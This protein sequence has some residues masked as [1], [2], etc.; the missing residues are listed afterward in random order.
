MILD[1][2]KL[3]RRICM[4]NPNYYA[5]DSQLT[6]PFLCYTQ[7]ILILSISRLLFQVVP[8]NKSPA[9]EDVAENCISGAR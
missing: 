1:S 3:Q 5:D 2:I 6:T 7:G 9:T 4:G 8:H